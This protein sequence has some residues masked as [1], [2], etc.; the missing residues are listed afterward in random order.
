MLTILSKKFNLTGGI[1]MIVFREKEIIPFVSKQD[2]HM[3]SKNYGYGHDFNLRIIL[4]RFCVSRPAR[5][6]C[7][8]KSVCLRSAY[9][10][11]I[12]VKFDYTKC[13]SYR[14]RMNFIQTL[15]RSNYITILESQLRL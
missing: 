15:R 11:S 12:L 1:R 9:L 8:A 6:G 5:S 7:M 3:S 13:D 4:L 10:A 2:V 14:H